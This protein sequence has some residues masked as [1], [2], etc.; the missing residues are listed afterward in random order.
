M[1][2]D[3]FLSL[4]PGSARAAWLATKPTTKAGAI[5]CVEHVIDIGL[6]TDET[7]G[8]LAMLLESPLVGADRVLAQDEEASA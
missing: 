6:V 2:S 5:S 1:A 4:M 7:K 8:W 3:A